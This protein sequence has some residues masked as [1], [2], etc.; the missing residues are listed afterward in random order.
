MKFAHAVVR[1]G[2]ETRYELAIP[3]S[4]LPVD[5][6]GAGSWYGLGILLNEQD[7]G[8]RGCYGWQGGIGGDKN[9]REFGQIVLAP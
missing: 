6:P 1:E 3:W 4:L 2:H 9:P 7:T 8:D 5:Q